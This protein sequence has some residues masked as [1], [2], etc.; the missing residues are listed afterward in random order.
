[1]WWKNPNDLFGQATIKT[2]STQDECSQR[3]KYLQGK[4]VA[5]RAESR[6]LDRPLHDA[7]K[8]WWNSN[9]SGGSQRS[10][11]ECLFR[12]IQVHQ[13]AEST[14]MQFSYNFSGSYWSHNHGIHIYFPP[15]PELFK[16]FSNTQN[17]SQVCASVWI[18]TAYTSK[19]KPNTCL[20]KV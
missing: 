2:V 5:R 9:N 14:C 3:H 12:K 10:Q 8:Q 1:M 19:L 13:M 20:Y 4:E 16:M 11:S 17:M 15:L 18:F 7:W 6:W